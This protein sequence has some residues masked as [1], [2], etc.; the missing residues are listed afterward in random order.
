[1]NQKSNMENY[2]YQPFFMALKTFRF[3]LFDSDDSSGSGFWSDM[4][5]FIDP[6]FENVP[7][8]SFSEKTVDFEVSCGVL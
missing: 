6:T 1:M 2:A 5:E 8:S 3:K 4:G 7:E